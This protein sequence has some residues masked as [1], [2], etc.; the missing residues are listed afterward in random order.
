MRKKILYLHVGWSKTG[1]SAVQSQIQRQKQDFL[2]KGILYPQSLQWPDHSHHPFALSF[3]PKNGGVYNSDMSMSEALSKLDQ[4]MSASSAENVLISSE[5][6][7]MY[8]NSLE[9]TNFAKEKFETVKILFTVRRQSELLISL[10]NQLVK[11]P[12]VR[13]K[14]SVFQL[15]MQNISQF[16]FYQRVLEWQKF[17]GRDNIHCF[18]YSRDIVKDFLAFFDVPFHAQDEDLV[19]NKSVPNRVIPLL[20][21]LPLSMSNAEYLEKTSELIQATELESLSADYSEVSIFSVG[22]QNSFD[23]YFSMINT[24]LS[25]EFLFEGFPKQK[26]YSQVIGYKKQ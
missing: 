14:G 22:E 15:G 8:F 16:N 17:V 9:F 13:Y 23:Q 6:S 1:T 12:N 3:K 18:T 20:Q 24:R 25:K 11:D 2:N 26:K 7:P 4:E 19:V 21:S 10:M 5:L